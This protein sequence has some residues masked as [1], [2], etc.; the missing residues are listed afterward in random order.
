MSPI[1]IKDLF[2]NKQ[3][4]IMHIVILNTHRVNEQLFCVEKKIDNFIHLYD[5]QIKRFLN[6]IN[7]V[8]Y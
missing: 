6:T 1:R 7:L 2:I 3:I 8:N 4:E 5:L